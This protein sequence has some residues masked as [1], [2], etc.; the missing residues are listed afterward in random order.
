MG[1]AVSGPLAGTQLAYVESGVGKW[2]EFAARNPGTEIFEATRVAEGSAE[3][4][5]PGLV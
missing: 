3:K 2:Y 1:E 5:S 4:Y